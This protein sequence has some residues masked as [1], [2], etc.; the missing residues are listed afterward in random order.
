MKQDVVVLTA[1]EIVDRLMSPE[2]VQDPYPLYARL[3]TIAPNFR[4]ARGVRFVSTYELVEELLI[5][6]D[7]RSDIGMPPVEVNLES[8]EFFRIAG[9][10]MPLLNPPVHTRIRSLVAPAF[11]H[12]MVRKRQADIQRRLDAL[13]DG[14]ERKLGSNGR[15]ELV[16]DLTGPL[17]LGV[18]CELIGVPQEPRLRQ[19]ARVSATLPGA[20]VITEDLMRQAEQVALEFGTFIRSLIDE[21][22]REP[23]EDTVSALIQAEA[24][25]EQLT[26]NEMISSLWTIMTAGF[27]TT[28]AGLTS[29][30]YLLL[31]NPDWRVQLASDPSLIS[32]A[33][34]EMLRFD[35]AV[36]CPFNRVAIRS[37]TLGGEA[38]QEGE[39]AVALIGAA[40]RDP[41]AFPDPDTVILDRP[42]SKGTASFGAGIHSCIGRAL[43]R[44]DIILTVDSFLRRFPNLRLAEQE[45]IWNRLLP[46]R[47]IS[48]LYVEPAV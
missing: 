32:S 12:K 39:R 3:R 1:D 6:K 27:E 40:N 31:L 48:E 29:V 23:G 46:V 33:V 20:P 10:S 9:L 4:S 35:A 2:I 14:I 11:S 19:W 15:A 7:F 28:T 5:S 18:F 22:R 13:L 44:H 21:R 42:A 8:S 47:Q 36:Q 38:V 26:E 37:T 41:E 24:E 25:G 16:E 45:I 30:L 34:D 43:S 17:P